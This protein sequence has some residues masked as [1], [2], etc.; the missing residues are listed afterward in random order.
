MPEKQ[1]PPPASYADFDDAREGGWVRTLVQ[2]FAIPFLIVCV[3]ITLYVGINLLLGSGPE[4]AGDFVALLQSDTINR[5]TQ[6]AYELARRLGSAE[7]PAEFR[8]PKLVKALCGAL[9]KARAENQKP[10][11]QA[12]VILVILARLADP[13]TTGTIRKALDDPHPWVRSYAIRALAQVGDGQSAALLREK[14]AF[15]D[16]PGT[17]QATLYALAKLEQVEGMAFHL[18]AG[19]RAIATRHL[20]DEKEDVRFTAALI[21]ADAGEREAALPVLCTMLDR[22]YLERFELDDSQSGLSRYQIHS[23][24]L[25][26]AIAAVV[27]LKS[28]DD[29]KVIALLQELTD[30]KTEGDPK[31]RQGARKALQKLGNKN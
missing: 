12:C 31:V 7:V 9:D 15:H 11:N 30:D 2:F 14:Y 13:A 29:A 27:K 17:R 6:A 19:T 25:L 1:Q 18:S 21:M 5:R 8:D 20:G 4:T 23:N 16:D 28:G 3:A 22:S 10:P 24:V 26:K